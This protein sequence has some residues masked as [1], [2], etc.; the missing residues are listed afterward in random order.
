MAGHRLAQRRYLIGAAICSAVYVAAVFGVKLLIHGAEPHGPL[1]IALAVLPALP[2]MAFVLVFARYLRDED[3]YQRARVVQAL[4]V[5]I[6]IG[7]SISSAWDFLQAYGGV[8]GPEP[9]IY[10]TGFIALFGLVQGFFKVTEKL[11]GGA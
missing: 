3:E 9:F 11:G 1:L 10:T 8:A 4:L 2:I 7:L 6:G 5:T